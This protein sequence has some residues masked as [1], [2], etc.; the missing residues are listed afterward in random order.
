VKSAVRVLGIL[1]FF[2]RIRGPACV[3]TVATG[4]G[5]PTSSTSALLRSLAA[6]GYLSYDAQARTYRPTERVPL[7]GNWVG[8]PFFQLGRVLSLVEGLAARTS[9]A[10]VL[11]RRTGL[12]MQYVHVAEA[13]GR[14]PP[15]LHIGAE[16]PMQGCAVGQ[17]LLA[18]MGEDS[19]GRLLR[20]LNA[21]AS[22]DAVVT[23]PMLLPQLA[24]VRA[25]GFALATDPVCTVLATRLPV[26]VGDPMF[27]G[28]AGDAVALT[29]R[30]PVLQALLQEEL[31][32]LRPSRA[33]SGCDVSAS[34]AANRL[35]ALHAAG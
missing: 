16:L 19:R 25:S 31:A 13:D 20:R 34:L 35:V 11:A 23:P 26:E 27:I 10:V 29:A 4:L 30:R 15:G 17:I 14:A 5:F 18:E 21:E 8:R 3:G 12:R 33:P 6:V 28:L 32:K 24:A 2:D 9:L 7:L 1:E 22:A